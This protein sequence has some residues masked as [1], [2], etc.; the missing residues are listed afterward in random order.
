LIAK[1]GRDAARG[2]RIAQLKEGVVDDSLVG[3]RWGAG[4]QYGKLNG[5][6]GGPVLRVT[7]DRNS[8][9]VGAWTQAGR[10]G[11]QL[12]QGT[13]YFR[14]EPSGASCDLRKRESPLTQVPKR[15]ELDLRYVT[16]RNSKARALRGEDCD[17][18]G[19]D[20]QANRNGLAVGQYGRS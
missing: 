19:G 20:M 12:Q 16:L 2:H 1:D 9:G 7:C 4:C 17:R 15:H 10:V 8:A 13:L 14:R 6:V 3:D 11:G 18:I 5:N